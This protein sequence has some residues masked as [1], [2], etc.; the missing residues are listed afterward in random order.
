MENPL[1][2]IGWSNFGL[3]YTQV[4]PALG[5]EE[6]QDPHNFIVK[7][8][9]ELGLVGGVLMIVWMMQFW[10]ELTRPIKALY[11]PRASTAGQ[12]TVLCFAAVSLATASL[13]FLLNTDW[14]QGSAWIVLQAVS[15][16]AG[17]ALLLTGL[18]AGALHS[19]REE[20]IEDRPAPWLL[21]ATLIAL[22]MFLLHNLIDFSL[23]EPGP[24][25]VFALLAGGAL[26]V[27]HPSV[28]G[29]PRKTV[30]T[31]GVFVAAVVLWLGAAGAIW[32]RTAF[33]EMAAANAD[34]LFRSAGITADPDKLDLSKLDQAATF[35][36]SAQAEQPLNFQYYVRAAQVLMYRQAPTLYT[37][38][39]I[40]RAILANPFSVQ[41][42]LL[43][44][45]YELASPRP[46]RDIIDSAYRRALQLNPRS[47]S[48][49]LDYAAALA[50]LDDRKA[51]AD[52]Y[53]DALRYDQELPP[54]EPKRLASS[55]IAE[56]QKQ[57][58]DLMRA[59]NP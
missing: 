15:A 22:G 34:Q 27:R 3:R 24:M 25:Y 52:Q 6:V 50:R 1:T 58:T 21:Y 29:R 19:L 9:V 11:I 12:R 56:I 45:G 2:G 31:V 43:K 5:V 49:R 41:A 23:F 10:W 44:A 51:A 7:S 48:V 18:V 39:M 26:G 13:N 37:R 53:R 46:E 59:P 30:V 14:N 42:Y 28:A 20:Q 57:I 4:R 16:A 8:F 54:D 40:E 36:Q 47:V 55:K 32:A 38:A 33:A 17:A 35:Y